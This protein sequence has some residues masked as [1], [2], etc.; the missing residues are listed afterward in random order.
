MSEKFVVTI[1]VKPYVKRFIELKYGFPADFSR[2]EEVKLL[3]RRCLKKPDTRYDRKYEYELCTH[4]E[5]L[6]ILISQDEFYKHGW[7]FSKTDIV[8]FGK[9]FEVP[10]KKKMRGIVCFYVGMGLNIKDS[11]LKYQK[12]YQMEEEFWP[13]ESIRKEYFRKRPTERIDFFDEIIDKIDELFTVNPSHK[14]D[15]FTLKNYTHETA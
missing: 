10:I 6:D 8:M 5:S 11:I 14:R 3:I 12:K 1:P 9:R 4:T 15:T 13:Y 7:E 2:D